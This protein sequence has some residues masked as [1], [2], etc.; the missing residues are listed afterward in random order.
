MRLVVFDTPVSLRTRSPS[1]LPW[2]AFRREALLPALGYGRAKLVAAWQ[3]SRKQRTSAAVTSRLPWSSA[4]NLPS[5]MFV[6]VGELGAKA[7]AIDLVA[8]SYWMGGGKY[9]IPSSSAL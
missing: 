1:S 3:H 8:T 2:P 7:I 9:S 5:L 4:N 6:I